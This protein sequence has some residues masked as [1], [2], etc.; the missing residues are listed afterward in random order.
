MDIVLNTA[1]SSPYVVQDAPPDV[2]VFSDDFNRADAAVLGSTTLGAFPYTLGANDAGIIEGSIVGNRAKVVS[3]NSASGRAYAILDTGTP[4]SIVRVQIA[5]NASAN[6]YNNSMGVAFRFL[7]V[8]NHVM[9]VAN[10]NQWR[11][12]RRN[13][14]TGSPILPLGAVPTDGD[15]LEIESRGTR[16]IVRIN[17]TEYADLTVPEYSTATKVALFG[18]GPT[19]APSPPLYDNFSQIVPGEWLI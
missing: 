1:F 12:F 13:A 4:D 16:V 7:D 17:G 9:I 11:L 3:T 18:A 19:T 5:A 14:G 10:S 2:V 8:S 15:I 6:A